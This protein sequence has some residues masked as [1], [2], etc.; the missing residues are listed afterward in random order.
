MTT[1]KTVMKTEDDECDRK[2]D[3][4][5]EDNEDIVAKQLN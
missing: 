2:C 5:S 4:G 1:E 3:V